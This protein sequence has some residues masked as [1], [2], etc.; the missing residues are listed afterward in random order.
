VRA[1]PE[2]REP[3]VR[4][5][6][7]LAG[8]L[9]LSSPAGAAG[10]PPAMV[11]RATF[12]EL[13][14]SQLVAVLSTDPWHLELRDRWTGGRLLAEHPVE[15]RG[16]GGDLVG[17]L[18]FLATRRGLPAGDPGGSPEWYR[19]R[20]VL[21]TVA[22][23][24]GIQVLAATDD[25][26]GRRMRIGVRFP[27]PGALSIRVTPEPSDGVLEVAEAL[28]S[29]PDE[30]YLGLGARFTPLDARGAEVRARVAAQL[31]SVRPISNHLPVPF[32]VSSRAYGVQVHGMEESVF[33]LNTVRSDAAIFKVRGPSLHFTVF[34]GRTPLDVV[35][36]HAK[37]SGPPALPP[38]WA[39]GVWKTVLGGEARV[40]AEA[41]RLQRERLPVTAVWSYDMV[42]E[43][44]HLGWRSWVYRS[45]APGS[46]PDLA[47]LTRRLRAMGYR[48]LGYLS[49]E[50]RTD[51]PLFAEGAA[52]GYFVRNRAGGPYV[53]PG[54]Q[55]HPV[56]LLDFTNPDAVRWWQALTG[57]ILI[58]L[59]FD[60]WM[61]DGGDDAPEDGV[62]VSGAR[63]AA[64]RNEY[65]AAYAQATRLGAM[66]V[67]SDYVS[68]MRSGFAGSQSH[69]PLAWPCDNVFSWSRRA[70]MP[71][72]LRATL[73]G[74]LSGFPFWAP[75]IGGYSGCGNG[76]PADEELWIRWLQL[77]ALHP[78]MRDHLGDKCGT[79]IDLWSTPGTVE[80]FR[81]YAAL[82]QRLV[83]YLYGIAVHTVETGLPLIRPVALMSPRDA[84]AYQDEFTYL[85]GD[86]LLVAPVVDADAR[87]RRVFLPEGEW[88]DWWDGRRYDGPNL[89]AVPAPLERIPLFVRAGS[90]L[91][92]ADASGRLTREAPG[93]AWKI[94]LVLRVYPSSRAMSEASVRLYD[95]TQ[96]RLRQPTGVRVVVELTGT[97]RHRAL[98]VVLPRRDAP[99][100]VRLGD[101]SMLPRRLPALDD[102]MLGGWWHDPGARETT[103]ILPGAAGQIEVTGPRPPTEAMRS[104]RVER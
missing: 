34:I 74:S 102:G 25:P 94:P 19:V 38:L 96:V 60:G 75:D 97:T 17:S 44:R 7:A 33:Q 68:L 103:I 48:T 39:F 5:L 21:G 12:L 36:R 6:L 55:G 9:L 11:R 77:G 10:A 91:P 18:G 42:D 20:S 4:C 35:A 73:S 57:S 101:G 64:A 83:P 79:V 50:F 22:Q 100:T 92:L 41:E 43:R 45:V 90:I 65:P 67:R 66:R 1:R 69:T 59:G 63:G 86:D 52:R 46:Y 53:K 82:H 51:A 29:E 28:R 49:P 30:H 54:M 85:I 78:V 89:I 31:D 27:S 37:A 13:Q 70:G 71:A 26:S 84:R 47:G 3:A 93:D 87:E 76:G 24:H 14:S 95:G 23:E 2:H 16:R 40:L 98:L 56:A 32:F 62:Y 58:E 81:R 72:A 61:Q 8:F 15:S 104:R 99:E 88:I 80:N